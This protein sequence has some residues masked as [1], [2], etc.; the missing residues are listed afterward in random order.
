MKLRPQS[1]HVIVLSLKLTAN[2]LFFVFGSQSLA[3]A[4]RLAFDPTFPG[5]II[6]SANCP[7]VMAKRSPRPINRLSC[8]RATASLCGRGRPDVRPAGTRGGLTTRGGGRGPHPGGRPGACLGSRRR[9]TPPGT[10]RP[11]QQLDLVQQLRRRQPT[12]R[13]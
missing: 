12:P 3:G 4:I 8:S 11:E 9:G 7:L 13:V 5:A 10:L 2:L 6:A 1:R